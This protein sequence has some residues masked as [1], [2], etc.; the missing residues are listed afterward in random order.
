MG[1]SLGHKLMEGHLNHP[2]A[3]APPLCFP[4]GHI[5]LVVPDV[6][7]A[8]RRFEELGVEFVKKPDEGKLR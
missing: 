5:G 1:C 6:G 8:C 3:P 4:A 2:L 7:A